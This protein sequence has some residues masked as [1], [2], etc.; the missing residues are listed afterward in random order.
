MPP[1]SP[2]ALPRLETHMLVTA[3][4][5]W[6]RVAQL[7][8]PERSPSPAQQAALAAL[9]ARRLAGEP[10]AYLLGEREFYGLT[11]AVSP[12]VLIPRPDTE[13]LVEVALAHLPPN[14]RVLDLG[15]GSGAV[16]LAIQHSRPD[17]TVSAVDVSAAALAVAQRNGAQL[18][19]AVQWQVSDWYSALAGQVFDL[20][21]SN[22]PYIAQTDPHLA[23]GDL[24]FEPVSALTDHADGLAAIRRI[25]ADAPSHLAAGGWL[26]MEHGWQQGEAVQALLT[27]QGWEAVAT[28]AD[29]AGHG[30]VTGGCWRGAVA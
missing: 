19:L 23:Q 14:G 13:T 28:V 30:R 5:G 6:S 26:W 21:V 27:A 11:L 8:H 10:M 4:T 2:P 18:G 3:V 12:D 20:I 9:V 7:T 29:L 16:A 15:T 25:V 17:A 22:P 24:R 1:S